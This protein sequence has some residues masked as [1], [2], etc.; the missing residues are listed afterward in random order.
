MADALDGGGLASP[1]EDG[2]SPQGT[3]QREAPRCPWSVGH[4]TA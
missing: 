3:R 1:G 2:A 4:M